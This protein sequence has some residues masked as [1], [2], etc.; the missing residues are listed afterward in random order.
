MLW[1]C[2]SYFFFWRGEV[3]RAKYKQAVEP[4]MSVLG[5]TAGEYIKSISLENEIR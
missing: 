2:P 4:S 5:A 1:S 3:Q